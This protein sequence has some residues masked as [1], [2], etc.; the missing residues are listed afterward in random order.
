M[1]SSSV[2]ILLIEDHPGSECPIQ[3][4]L[5]QAGP[6]SFDVRLATRLDEGLRHLSREP[7]DVVLLDLSLPDGEGLD[8]LA[9]VLSTRP[10]TPV[11]VLAERGGEDL[12]VRALQA[13]A[14]DYLLKSEITPQLLRRSIRYAR[15]RSQT[16]GA[17]MESRERYALALEG[18]NDGLWD[19]DLR[20]GRMYFSQRWKA[21]LGYG[22]G[23]IEDDPEEW[24]SRVH[25]QD[26]E[27]LRGR[28]DAHL[29]GLTPHFE[30]EHRIRARGGRLIWV[31]ARGIVVR[32]V[33]GRPTRMAGSLTDVTERK[34]VEERLRHEVLH[35]ELTSL[36]NRAYFSELLT[37]ALGRAQR[38]RGYRFA[39]LFLDM[40]RFKLINDSLGHATGDR[41]LELVARRLRVCLRPEDTVARLSGD[42]FAVMVDAIGDAEDAVRVAERIQQE[43]RVP[44]NLEGREIFTSVS[45]GIALSH[46]RYQRPDDLLRDADIAMYRA[47]NAGK[48]RHEL[49][50]REMH[51]EVTRLLQM[52]TDLR[53]ALERD[54][55][56]IHYQPVVDLAGRRILGFE[57]L[58]RWE[59]PRRGMIPPDEFIPVAEETGLMVP[60]GRWVLAQACRRLR[61]WGERYPSHPGV[62]MSVN[63]SSRQWRDPGLLREIKEQVAVAGVD[64]SRLSLEITEGVIMADDALLE[65]RVAQ[66]RELGL[67]LHIDDF[68][69]GYS[70]LG[71]LHRFPI[72]T[73]K[74]D[75]TFT[76]RLGNG[77]G[78]E[79]AEIVRTIVGLARTLNLEVVA[80]GVE[81]E[82]QA[83]AL[84]GL[85]CLQGQ[86]YFFSRPV[87]HTV[88]EALLAREALD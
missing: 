61:E 21:M 11:V 12:A 79:S 74:I 86:G 26:R 62:R 51:V 6:R 5:R 78:G 14:Q 29:Q 1:E 39:V 22:E 56:R 88:A 19:W 67:K 35:D 40:D 58:L 83:A 31:L 52:E 46:S 24:F 33:R 18:A 4:A 28:I 84:R 55:F 2:Q 53:R 85:D 30:H 10:G 3:D 64:A 42:E 16:L 80:E 13:G 82:S 9:R 47:K 59:H 71:L 8:L 27:T 15:E 54:Q 77:G 37:R 72:D 66:L 45:I 49:F 36:P 32:D 70:S 17:L 48:A 41:V 38:H 20:E 73:L 69:T 76:A 34:K 25:S 23:G 75:R 44:F 81:T 50:D 63:L 60:I 7:V 43:L 65:G 87:E 68:G 57:A